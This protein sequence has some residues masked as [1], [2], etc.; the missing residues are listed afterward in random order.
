MSSADRHGNCP[1]EGPG[2][3]GAEERAVPRHV[4]RAG[5]YLLEER[6]GRCVGPSQLLLHPSRRA[7]STGKVAGDASVL[8]GA[9]VQPVSGRR[10]RTRKPDRDAGVNQRDHEGRAIAP[11]VSD[12]DWMVGAL[13]VEPC[14]AADEESMLI[15]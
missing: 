10:D 11:T 9:S 2:S 15:R 5:R 12:Q 1:V 3:A 13:G 8:H 6:D 4:Q 7:R 14:L